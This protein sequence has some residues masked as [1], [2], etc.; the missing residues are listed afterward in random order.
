MS[1]N[2]SDKKKSRWDDD[3]DDRGRGRGRDH[4]DK[5]DFCSVDLR[6]IGRDIPLPGFINLVQAIVENPTPRKFAA[7]FDG[8]T[9]AESDFF[10]TYNPKA[11]LHVETRDGYLTTE[12]GNGGF[13]LDV[14]KDGSWR[15]HF[16]G[17]DKVIGRDADRDCPAAPPPPPP[18]D[19]EYVLLGASVRSYNA[20]RGNV[21]VDGGVGW[22]TIQ[23]GV[24]DYMIGGSGTLGGGQDGQGNCAIYS[25]STTAVLVDMENGFGYGGTAEGNVLVNMNQVRGS[26]HSNVLIGSHEGSDMKSGA[27]NTLMISTGGNGFE[28]RPDGSGNVMVSTVGEDWIL[29]DPTKGWQLGDQNIMLGFD[30]E[31]GGLAS[32][33][34]VGGDFLDLRMLTDVAR[35]NFRTS[36]AVGYDPLT[37]HGDIEAY[38]KILDAADGSHVMFSA[39]GNVVTAGTEIL[40]LKYVHG[41]DTQTLFDRGNIVA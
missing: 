10:W 30:P 36:S 29:F 27:D 14:Q 13:S 8:P 24:G 41:L 33:G 22:S 4:D 9:V 17:S 40:S 5:R 25:Q 6:D 28:M 35:S 31:C 38:V 20:V 37:G 11:G 18:E 39:S 7:G 2:K 34:D 21:T 1:G 3:D 16:H 32:N 12:T 19:N 15:L 23:G 26:L